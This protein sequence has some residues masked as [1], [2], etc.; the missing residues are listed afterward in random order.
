LENPP[1]VASAR[2]AHLMLPSGNMTA[3]TRWFPE[4]HRRATP[5]L[6]SGA[7]FQA[8]AVDPPIFG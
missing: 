5:A 3:R 1:A 7:Q 6:V 2:R 4:P 8:E